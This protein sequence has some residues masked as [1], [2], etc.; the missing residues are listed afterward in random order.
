MLCNTNCF[1]NYRSVDYEYR[2]VYR[3][4]ACSN[5]EIVDGNFGMKWKVIVRTGVNGVLP[6]LR[7]TA[8]PRN[9][10]GHDREYMPF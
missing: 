3:S 4:W 2:S 8:A 7:G 9:W 5:H 1:S 6:R 10:F